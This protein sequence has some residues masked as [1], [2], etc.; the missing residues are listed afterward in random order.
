LQ[1]SSI[2]LFVKIAT[3][4]SLLLLYLEAIELFT[5]EK[6]DSRTSNESCTAV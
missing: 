6:G 4:T 3:S 2:L 5:N 1:L